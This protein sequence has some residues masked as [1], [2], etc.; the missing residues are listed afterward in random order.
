MSIAIAQL[1]YAVPTKIVTNSVSFCRSFSFDTMF[2]SFLQFALVIFIL[3]IF[4][5]TL[6]FISIGLGY[7]C[8]KL[9]KK[10]EKKG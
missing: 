10:Y 4:S 2:D 7:F 5:V 8:V 6:L 9:F 1:F 3:L